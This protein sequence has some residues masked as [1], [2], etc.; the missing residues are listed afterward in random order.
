LVADCPIIGE[1]SLFPQDLP[2]EK[3]YNGGAYTMKP[4]HYRREGKQAMDELLRKVGHARRRLALQRF[5]SILGWCWFAALWMAA[6]L[7]VVER[8]WPLQVPPGAW[9]AGALGLGLLVA[10]GWTWATAARPLEAAIEIDRR[11][12][13]KERVSSTL[14]MPANQQ[15]SAAGSALVA[16][17]LRRLGRVDVAERFR[18]RPPRQ[19]LLPL[20]PALLVGLLA[21][22]IKPADDAAEAAGTTT[23][24]TKQ[25]EVKKSTDLLRQSLA[26]R[27]REAEKQG[28]KDM[29]ELLKK[30]EDGTRELAAE[31]QREKAL[32]KLNDLSRELMQRRQQVGGAEKLKQQLDQLKHLDRGPADKFTQALS[33]GDFKKAA[34]ELRKIQDG[35]DKSKLDD[36]QKGELA[37]QLEQMQQKLDQLATARQEALTDMQNQADQLSKAGQADDARKLE[38]QINKLLEQGPQMG[39]MQEIAQELGQCSKC[40]QQGQ[41]Q[42]AAEALGQAQAGLNK[43]QQQLEELET[44][45]GAMEQLAQARDRMNCAKCGGAGC[46]ACQGEGDEPGFGLGLGRARAE[47]PRPEQKTETSLYDSQVRQQVGKGSGSVTGLVDGPNIRGRQEAD[48]QQQFDA[49]RRGTTDP[50]TGQ[51]LPQKHREHAREYFD[52]FREGR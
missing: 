3:R 49:A 35:L 36:A 19:L 52:R 33:R 9:I 48:I 47:G 38:E 34:E 27:R 5:L 23:A 18:L 17:A 7:I 45:D 14:A 44:L 16:D 2:G 11:Y 32:V 22:L 4:V 20:L 43:L 24:E 46:P 51:R 31:P 30:L 8:F 29:S 25:P 37:K 21:V 15:Q 40:L 12:G 28:L 50:L 42:N 1:N 41:G 13:L 26:E 39:Q 10:G 6:A